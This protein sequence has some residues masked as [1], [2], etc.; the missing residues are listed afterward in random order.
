[1]SDDKIRELEQR[2]AWLTGVVSVLGHGVHAA[3][4]HH[5][6]REA[7]ASEI[8]KGYEDMISRVL[9]S[10]FPD[11]FVEGMQAARDLYLLKPD[12]LQEPD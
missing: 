8:H 2:I 4:K 3:I 1:M 6:D 5:P 10:A 11:K 12:R 9:P 7:V